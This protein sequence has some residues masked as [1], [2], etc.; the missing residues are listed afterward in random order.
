MAATSTNKQ[1]LLV[2]RVFHEAYDM[3]AYKVTSN[4][5]TPGNVTGAN[6]AI[7]VLDSITED[8]A[9]IECIYAIAR[10]TTAYKINFYYSSQGDYL[11]PDQAVYIGQMTAADTVNSRVEWAVMPA[12]LAPVPAMAQPGAQLRALYLPKGK[13]MWA[14]IQLDA[15]IDINT[16]LVDA[17][18]IGL[19][20]GFY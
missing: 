7:K 2:D 17:P 19:Q 13:A 11:R 16:Q 5:T 6:T 20:G 1:P 8:G 18:I 10:G 3:N 15:G 12:V 9:V 14:A 4:T